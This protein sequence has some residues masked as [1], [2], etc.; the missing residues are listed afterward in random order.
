VIVGRPDLPYLGRDDRLF[1]IHLFGEREE[2]FSRFWKRQREGR[3]RGKVL[4]GTSLPLS[5]N[6]TSPPTSGR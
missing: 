5:N 3:W 1:V 2:G 4:R 6:H